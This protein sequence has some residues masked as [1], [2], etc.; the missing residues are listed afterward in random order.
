MFCFSFSGVLLLFAT[1][2][3]ISQ[4]T[5]AVIGISHCFFELNYKLLHE[6]EDKALGKKP[7]LKIAY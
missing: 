3:P 1:S 7:N 5:N 2:M 4:P 6:Y